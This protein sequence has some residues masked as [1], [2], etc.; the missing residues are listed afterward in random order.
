MV[1]PRGTTGHIGPYCSPAFSRPVAEQIVVD[2]HS[3]NCGLT[4]RWDGSLLVFEWTPDYDGD[5]GTETVTPDEHGRYRI[6]GRWPWD[7]DGPLDAA[8][9][10]QAAHARSA[11]R[12]GNSPPLVAAPVLASAGPTVAPAPGR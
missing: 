1:D 2:L 3:D 9:R 5:G 10:H 11:A 12:L 7:Y 6:G 4:G 8:E